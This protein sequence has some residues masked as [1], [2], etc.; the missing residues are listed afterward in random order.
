MPSSAVR[1]FTDPDD[2]ASA[3]RATNAELTVIGRGHFIGKITSPQ[4]QAPETYNFVGILDAMKK[5]GHP[6]D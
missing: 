5:G 1:T 2:Y 3:I 6:S 4:L